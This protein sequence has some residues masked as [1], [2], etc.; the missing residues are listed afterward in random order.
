MNSENGQYFVQQW[1]EYFQVV[2]NEVKNGVV[3]VHYIQILPLCVREPFS[4]WR[5]ARS[6]SAQRSGRTVIR[7]DVRLTRSLPTL[8]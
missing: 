4:G 5:S 2:L 7:V 6:V 8:H 3:F 1:G